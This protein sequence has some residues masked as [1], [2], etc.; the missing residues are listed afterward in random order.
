M[1]FRFHFPKLQ[2]FNRTI[3]QCCLELITDSFELQDFNGI[4]LICRRVDN[5]WK[6]VLPQALT[7]DTIK[8]YHVVL[9]HCGVN[10]LISSLRAHLWIPH[11]KEQV[12]DFVS[13]CDH[14]QRYK[15]PGPGYG[16][17]PPWNDVAIPWEEVSVDLVGP[18]KIQ[19]PIGEL[20]VHAITMIDMT[21]TLAECI[22][23]KNKTACHCTM[24][25]KNHWLS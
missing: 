21:S 13:H 11:L 24:Q 15:F 19:L 3:L 23:I 25:F 8:W 16:E 2:S 18:W 5:Q 7:K 10:R 20:I 1:S 6:I 14:C 17:L 22:R 9:G 12:T 4:E